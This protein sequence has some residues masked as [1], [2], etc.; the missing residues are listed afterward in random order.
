MEIH[1][2]KD[3]KQK[4]QDHYKRNNPKTKQEMANEEKFYE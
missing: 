3:I 1:K 4:R 2:E